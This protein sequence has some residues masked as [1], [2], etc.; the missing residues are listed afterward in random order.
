MSTPQQFLL[1]LATAFVVM[2]CNTPAPEPLVQD[3]AEPAD[4]APLPSWNEGPIKQAIIDF[5]QRTTTEGN[6]EFIAI[7][8]RIAV[9][10][11]RRWFRSWIS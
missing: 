5:V 3:L 9:F 2:A 4:A 1:G 8:E 6:G 7:P 10:H 11:N